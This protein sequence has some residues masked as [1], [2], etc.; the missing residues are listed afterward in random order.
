MN[1]L[2]RN[3]AQSL[4]GPKPLRLLL[5]QMRT[6]LALIVLV[7]VFSILMPNRF[8]H[9]N[10][11][12]ILTKQ[13]AINAILGIGVTFVILTGGIDLSVGSIVGLT[14]MIAGGL[15]Y[16]GLILRP[17]GISIF[18]NVW[19]VALIALAVGVLIGLINGLLITKFNVPPFIATL[20]TMYMA[21]D[22]I[23]SMVALSQPAGHETLGNQGSC[24]GTE[25]FPYLPIPSGS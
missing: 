17:F 1:P 13:V 14:G 23:R 12:V 8:L 11:L 19:I 4:G 18:F 10:N 3:S 20:G 5:L 22:S 2:N 25:D 21:R 7:V 15:I 16:E 9:V 24:S 6:F